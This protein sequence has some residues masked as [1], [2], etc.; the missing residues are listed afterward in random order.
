MAMAMDSAGNITAVGTFQGKATFGATTLTSSGPS[1]GFVLRLDSKGKITW[2][3][4]PGIAGAEDMFNDVACNGSGTCYLTGTFK[5]NATFGAT[6]LK[7]KGNLDAFV[8]RISPAGTFV[9]AVG[10]GGSNF[11][12]GKGIALGPKGTIH[13]IG[14]YEG[15]A[16]FG[17]KTLTSTGGTIDG[18]VMV[19]PKQ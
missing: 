15:S 10:A 6:T 4:S 9:W 11:D 14:E 1:D 5:G 16:T 13:V 3:V 17:T 7:A 8:A 12:Q 18:F 2:V 19:M